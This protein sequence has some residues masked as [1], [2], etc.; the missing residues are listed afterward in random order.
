MA[1]H[2]STTAPGSDSVRVT[3]RKTKP[4]AKAA[5]ALT[6]SFPR[7]LTKKDS[8][9]ARPLMVNGMSVTRKSSGPIT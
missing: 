8:R 9:T 3:A 6:E 5:S 4:A 1:S 2:P 7:K